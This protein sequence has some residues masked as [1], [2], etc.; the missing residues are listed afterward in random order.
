[1]VGAWICGGTCCAETP[2]EEN[3]LATASSVTIANLQKPL[4]TLQF[5][6]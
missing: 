6:L 2:N 3:M 1:L 4:R 5:L